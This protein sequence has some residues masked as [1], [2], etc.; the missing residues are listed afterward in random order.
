M[1]PIALAAH[2]IDHHGFTWRMMRQYR[3]R[4]MEQQHERD[5]P[6]DQRFWEGPDKQH[7]HEGEEVITEISGERKRLQWWGWV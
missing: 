3:T 4:A 1:E 2:M 7:F 6:W 5:H